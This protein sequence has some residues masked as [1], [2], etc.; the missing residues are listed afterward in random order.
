MESWLQQVRTGAGLDYPQIS[1]RFQSVMTPL[2]LQQQY[3]FGW[4]WLPWDGTFVAAVLALAASATGLFLSNRNN[5]A[6]L[7]AQSIAQKSIDRLSSSAAWFARFQMAGTQLENRNRDIKMA[8]I[9]LLHM[10]KDDP[11]AT[12]AEKALV[13]ELLAIFENKVGGGG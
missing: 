12:S 6:T 5:N 3:L 2:D 11:A 4:S 1:G 9:V 8:G 7:K 10:L 13:V